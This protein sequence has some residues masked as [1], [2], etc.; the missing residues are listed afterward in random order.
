MHQIQYKISEK[1][2]HCK[3]FNDFH[4]YFFYLC[5]TWGRAL[6]H[7]VARVLLGSFASLLRCCELLDHRD[8]GSNLARF[9]SSLG[10]PLS[11][12]CLR[13]VIFLYLQFLYFPTWSMTHVN[14]VNLRKKKAAFQF[15]LTSL[16]SAQIKLNRDTRQLTDNCGYLRLILR[17]MIWCFQCPRAAWFAVNATPHELHLGKRCEIW[18][19]TTCIWKQNMLQ[20][21][22]QICNDKHL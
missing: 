10:C 15:T 8:P 18:S 12:T 14:Y 22:S 20:S 1:S 17:L 21:S 16:I 5:R 19:L 6:D 4:A 11:S 13:E 2:V 9:K 7:M 3:S